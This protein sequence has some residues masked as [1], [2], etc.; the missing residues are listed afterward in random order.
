MP[1]IQTEFADIVNLWNNYTIRKQNAV[2]IVSGKP[3]S[4]YF[5]SGASGTEDFRVRMEPNSFQIVKDVVE[6]DGINLDKYL[7]VSTLQICD[8]I[9]TSI[10][11]IP[12]KVPT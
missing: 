6:Q 9:I 4:L 10:G 3:Y 1:I 11:G 2:Y 8:N 12:D 5:L 7:P